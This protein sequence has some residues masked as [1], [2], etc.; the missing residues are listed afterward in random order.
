MQLLN[1]RA[2]KTEHRAFEEV[3]KASKE[4]RLASKEA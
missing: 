1:I 4:V 3:D 2:K